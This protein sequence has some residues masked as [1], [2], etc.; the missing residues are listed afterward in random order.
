METPK[1][2]RTQY[3]RNAASTE[4]YA[5]QRK[6]T[7]SNLPPVAEKKLTP[8]KEYRR[9]QVAAKLREKRSR[10]PL[11][12][13]SLCIP[14]SGVG[15]AA[16]KAATRCRNPHAAKVEAAMEVSSHVL[17]WHEARNAASG[18]PSYYLGAGSAPPVAP[19][20]LVALFTSALE[21]DSSTVVDIPRIKNKRSK[22]AKKARLT[23]VREYRATSAK[24]RQLAKKSFEAAL[25]AT[26]VS[27]RAGNLTPKRARTIAG[28][29]FLKLEILS[30]N[31]AQRMLED[32][33]NEPFDL[34]VGGVS[35]K[36]LDAFLESIKGVYDDPDAPVSFGE[37]PKVLGDCFKYSYYGTLA[38]HG[39][40]VEVVGGKEDSQV[41]PINAAVKFNHSL[42]IPALDDD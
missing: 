42:L 19:A 9:E 31:K 32:Y 24:I 27:S 40:T 34:Y 8:R 17:A 30:A 39:D 5:R 4:Q 1:S 15:R 38:K 35:K 10:L 22:K 20:E 14:P 33:A 2:M 16:F 21:P 7:A 23:L 28:N 36:A 3:F 29:L 37:A 25:H 26:R 12:D 11:F 6:F 41:F 18:Q 13:E